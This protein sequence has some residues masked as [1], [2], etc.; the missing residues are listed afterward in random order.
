[1]SNSPSQE[2]LQ[3][4]EDAARAF[5]DRSKLSGWDQMSEYDKAAERGRQLAAEMVR[6]N[7]EQRKLVES[8]YGVPYCRNRWPEAYQRQPGFISAF[9][10]GG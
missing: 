3:P 9:K 6:T 2:E 4:H 5:Q 1:M 7:P 10:L 8:V